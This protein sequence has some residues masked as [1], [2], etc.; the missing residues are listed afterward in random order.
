M[1]NVGRIR[2]VDRGE[3]A[4]GIQA[5]S[6]LTEEVF[7]PCEKFF[8]GHCCPPVPAQTSEGEINFA[9]MA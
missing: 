9:V 1:G 6:R 4:I 3:A 2:C 5:K 7:P 8:L